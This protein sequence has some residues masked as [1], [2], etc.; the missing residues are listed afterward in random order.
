MKEIKRPQSKKRKYLL[1]KQH[2]GN[3]LIQ[4]ITWQVSHLMSKTLYSIPG[5]LKGTKFK[6]ILK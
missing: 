2:K 4:T 3:H 6:K 1:L 5:Y